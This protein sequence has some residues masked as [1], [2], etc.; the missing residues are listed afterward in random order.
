M[1]HDTVSAD[2]WAGASCRHLARFGGL[3]LLLLLHD[4]WHDHGDLVATD[5]VARL[6]LI[7]TLQAETALVVL[8]DVIDNILALAEGDDG[9]LS[10][11]AVAP[12]DLHSVPLPEDPLHHEA[13]SHVAEPAPEDGLDVC[14]ALLDQLL[15]RPKL[16]LERRHYGLEELVDYFERSDLHTLLLGKP[17]GGRHHL[18]VEADDHDSLVLRTRRGQLHVGVRDGA[19]GREHPAEV[20]VL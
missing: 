16:V 8:V 12:V 20:D 6:P 1:V 14:P 18:G 2:G 4:V 10:D 7:P 11:T 9:P 15:L 17:L 13:A 5:R 19:R 3:P